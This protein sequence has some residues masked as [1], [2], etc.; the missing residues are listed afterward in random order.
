MK[1]S[2]NQLSTTISEHA[3]DV[4]SYIHA[5]NVSQVSEMLIGGLTH[6]TA[7]DYSVILDVFD[8]TIAE[9]QLVIDTGELT[10][11]LDG[12]LLRISRGLETAAHAGL[13]PTGLVYKRLL[14]I[15]GTLELLGIDEENTLTD[16]KVATLETAITDLNNIYTITEGFRQAYEYLEQE[17]SVTIDPFTKDS[18]CYGL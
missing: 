10:D 14:Q 11:A 18:I 2:Q 15:S 9:I 7:P 12:R 17:G 13:H 16:Q 8:E 6:R 5:G 1:N 3:T 4:E